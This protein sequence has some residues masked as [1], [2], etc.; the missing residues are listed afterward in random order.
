MKT[1]RG[2]ITSENTIEG[3]KEATVELLSTILSEN[4]ISQDEIL[5]T[6]FSATKDINK[7]YPAK[8]A[9]ECLN[10]SN[11]P[12]MCYQEMDV[13]GSLKKCIRVQIVTTSDIEEIKHIYLKGASSLRPDLSKK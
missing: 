1:I 3:I 9:R 11:V 8:F 2:A 13:A 12:M 4:R 5:F 6:N 10:F 7:A